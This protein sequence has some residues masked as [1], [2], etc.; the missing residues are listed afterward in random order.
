M[1]IE[2][3]YLLFIK[4]VIKDLELDV[5]KSSARR[6]FLRQV[7]TLIDDL[8]EEQKII[9]NK[10]SDKDE[11][12]NPKFDGK[13]QPVFSDNGKNR[14]AGEELK[15]INSLEVEIKKEGNEKDFEMVKSI[16]ETVLSDFEKKVDGKYKDED[17]DFKENL[18]LVISKLS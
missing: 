12:G 11:K 5:K 3:R 14:Q 15:K 9:V 6:R 13:G 10:F 1:I 17:F 7:N 2:N 4:N 16:F 8:I 18:E